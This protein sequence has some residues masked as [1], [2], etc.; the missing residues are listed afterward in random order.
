M[1]KIFIFSLL[2]VLSVDLS[3]QNNKGSFMFEGGINLKESQSEVQ[4]IGT[5]GIS[6]FKRN[7]YENQRDTYSRFY[8]S[9]SVTGYSV[10]PKIGYF[11]FN[12]TS[13]GVDF[14]YNKFIDKIFSKPDRYR[15]TLYGVFIRHYFGNKKLVPVIESGTGFGL[16]KSINN[17]VSAGG[18]HYQYIKRK[19]LFYISGS[20]GISYSINSR[21]RINLLA[22]AQRTSEKPLESELQNKY[23]TDYYW[24]SFVNYDS[25]LILS[26]SYFLK[27]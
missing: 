17:D 27:K 13:L 26:F 18:G 3:A 5:N 25:A 19:D 8:S 23:G 9:R 21:F 4:T 22:K 15:T 2:F 6:F 16:F 14:Q 7:T 24:N 20:A 11:L 1:K 12:N 10:A